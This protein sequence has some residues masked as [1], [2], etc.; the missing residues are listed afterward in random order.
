[1]KLICLNEND[2]R[3]FPLPRLASKT[4]PITLCTA[5]CP[6][7]RTIVYWGGS[8]DRAKTSNGSRYSDLATAF[9]Y[10]KKVASNC[11]CN[12][13]DNFGTAAVSIREDITLRPGDI[14]VTESGARVFVGTSEDQRRPGDFISSQTYSGLSTGDRR[15]ISEIQVTRSNS[16]G[17]KAMHF[18]ARVIIEAA[19]LPRSR[20]RSD[21]SRDHR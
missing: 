13:R 19:P 12:G 2:G 9:D 10:R 7:T 18:N 14:V 16:L 15:K 21:K 4:P 5:L 11:T 6:G 3:Y 1:M 17:A 8:I 20:R